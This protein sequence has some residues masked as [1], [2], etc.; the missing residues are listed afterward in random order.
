[1]TSRRSFILRG[2]AVVA[3]AAAAVPRM[4]RPQQRPV[5]DVKKLGAF[6]NG[7]SPDLRQIQR[8]IEAAAEHQQGATIYFPPGEYYLG[9]VDDTY[10]LTARGLRNVRFAGERATLTCR[11]VGGSSSI[12][13]LA[14]CENVSVEGLAFRDHGAN[15]DRLVGAAAVRL[16][17]EGVV[18]CRGTRISDCTFD[19]VIAGVVCRH[20]DDGGKARTRGISLSNLAVT[21]AYYGFNFQDAGDEV[22]GRGL[23]CND[24]RRSYFPFGVDRHDI[25]LDT[26][27]NTTGYTD[28]LIKCYERDTSAVRVKVR[29]RGKRGGDAIVALDH[30]HARGQGTIRDVT[31]DLDI[32]DADCR[33]STAILVRS[34]TPGERY[35]RETSNRWD[36]ISIDG[37][38][39][40]CERTKLLD[41]ATVGKRTGRLHIGS[42]LWKNPRLPKSFPGFE[43]SH[44]T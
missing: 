29:C 14:G 27:N 13:V 9:T 43:V 21:H 38:V 4:A 2:A 19:S 12:L 15:R 35:E 8:A 3:G 37:D 41:I 36:N 44:S 42:R 26:R 40:I 7:N 30:Q 32:D 31:L 33:L 16:L 28:V 25:E 6:G 39:R 11:T 34:F 18:G 1:M 10:L 24:V 22:T 23:T 17:N 20:F 5:I